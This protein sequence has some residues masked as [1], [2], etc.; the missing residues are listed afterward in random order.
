MRRVLLLGVVFLSGCNGI[1]PSPAAT[2]PTPAPAVSDAMIDLTTAPTLLPATGGTARISVYTAG[3]T[4][5]TPQAPHTRVTLS[6]STGTLKQTEVVTDWTGNGFTEWTGDRTGEITATANGITSRATVAV[7]SAPATQ[8]PPPPST[9]PPPVPPTPPPTGSVDIVP[10]PPASGVWATELAVYEA[11]IQYS[12]AVQDQSIEWDF[13][14][15]GQTD[16]AGRF[17]TWT[18]ATP[19]R[20]DIAI[21][22]KADNGGTGSGSTWLY[23]GPIDDLTVTLTAD[24]SP[25][26]LYRPVT[27]TAYV[28]SRNGVLPPMTFTFD[29]GI[30]G[31]FTSSTNSTTCGYTNPGL[32]TATVSVAAPDG[33]PAVQATATVAVEIPPPTVSI[34]PSRSSAPLNTNITFTATPGMLQAGET[35]SGYAWDFGDGGTATTAVASSEHLYTTAGTRAAKVT[36]TTSSGRTATA[37]VAVTITP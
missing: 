15:D 26:V 34:V 35:V 19:G 13:N 3:T 4:S 20:H 24:P 16:R 25:A 27:L 32:H 36:M 11:K 28:T 18:Y 31:P 7:P 12:G 8:P 21:R 29:C 5:G 6:A 17:V 37:T 33:R 30:A 22:A 14:S 10:L 23:V 2:E 1:P 9:P